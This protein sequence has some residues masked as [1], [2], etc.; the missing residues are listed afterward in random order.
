MLVQ[1]RGAASTPVLG[2]F[3][4]PRAV[5]VLND[6]SL[7]GPEANVRSP[8]WARARVATAG[9]TGR[10]S[11]EPRA[12]GGLLAARS[13]QALLGARAFA[14][15]PPPRRG[16]K[17]LVPG[18]WDGGAAPRG[19][20]PVLPR[21]GPPAGARAARSGLDSSK[22]DALPHPHPSPL[23]LSTDWG[24]ANRA[25]LSFPT[26]TICL[27]ESTQSGRGEGPRL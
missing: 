17:P 26:F 13:L 1:E 24:S 19:G 15:V 10:D 2:V 20:A 16:P 22:A 12:W 25:S 27:R 6:R 9:R 14:E 4:G 11:P 5:V 8:A 7:L 18:A 23:E 3:P 21:A